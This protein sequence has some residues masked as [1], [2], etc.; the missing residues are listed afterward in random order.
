MSWVT[1][2]D[3]FPFHRKVAG[4]SDAAFRLHT[5]AIF[6]CRA[7]ATDGLIPREDLTLVLP[8]MRQ[9][10]RYASECVHRDVWHDARFAC[11]SV[12]CPAPV[13]AD[14]WVIHDYFALH[15]TKAE[16]VTAQVNA[17]AAKSQ[18][19]KLG[20]HR[21]WHK[22][23][24]TSPDCPWCPQGA[25]GM[26]SDTESDSDRSGQSVSDRLVIALSRSRSEPRSSDG[27]VIRS[28]TERNARTDDDLIL[29]T[30]IETIATVTGVSIDASW[31][32]A[33]AANI[34]GARKPK[35]PAAYCRQAIQN[36]PDPRA[37]FLPAEPS[38]LPCPHCHGSRREADADGRD[39]GP[40]PECH[41]K[42]K[43]KAS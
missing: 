19:G 8:R 7:N 6:W 27:S 1:F 26:R 39:I 35:D 21:K 5:A 20:N 24:R 16:S 10:A 2:D 33:V 28:R 25:I 11:P 41:P 22:D 17:S 23:G 38:P 13:D 12:D 9:P 31:A 30:I 4:L 36:D 43:A 3:K 14:G 34:L 32:A 37:R 42:S 18:G 15:P 29:K 40:C